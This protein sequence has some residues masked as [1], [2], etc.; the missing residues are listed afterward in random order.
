MQ[1]NDDGDDNESS[2]QDAFLA[3]VTSRSLTHFPLISVAERARVCV[4]ACARIR[5]DF[6]RRTLGTDNELVHSFRARFPHGK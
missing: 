2:E 5:N 3:L 1:H 4:C 6:M